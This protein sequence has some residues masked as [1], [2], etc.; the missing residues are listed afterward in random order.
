M[1]GVRDVLARFRPAGA[2]GAA[3]PAGVPAD[4]RADL[5]RELEPVFAALAATHRECV[6]LRRAAETTASKTV[7][8]AQ[9]RARAMAARAESDAD[10]DRA[11]A[12][13]QA[14][15]QG[16][17]EVA[18]IAETAAR[19]AERV[20]RQAEDLMPALVDRLVDRVRADLARVVRAAE[21]E[22]HDG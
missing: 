4:R 5:T 13:A 18:E 22:A 21:S 10:A 1:P 8:R 15:A 11:R 19:E 20:R 16:E 6:A 7:A 12:A 2:P 14:R 17:A 3:T 9:E